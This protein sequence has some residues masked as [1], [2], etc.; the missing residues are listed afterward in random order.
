MSPLDRIATFILI[1]HPLGL[2]IL[3]QNPIKTAS[4]NIFDMAV[5]VQNGNGVPQNGALKNGNHASEM[6]DFL[7]V[8]PS[9]HL[10]PLWSQMSAMVPPT[11]NPTAKAHIW[12]YEESLPYL[13]TAG[14]LVPEEKAERRVLMLVNPS[15]SEFPNSASPNPTETNPPSQRLHTL[16]IPYMEAFSGS[17]LGRQHRRIDTLA[18]PVASSLMAKASLLLRARRCL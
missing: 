13:E 9:Q 14:R 8:L 2:I 16:R 4:H 1:R 5:P 15:M 18:L 6:T 3:L 11:P 10:E 17:I 7:Q 12:K